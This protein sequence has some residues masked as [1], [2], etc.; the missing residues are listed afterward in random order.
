MAFH[1]IVRTLPKLAT[2]KSC[3]NPAGAILP[4]P[5]TQ[6]QAALAICGFAVWIIRKFIFVSKNLSS[7]G[8]PSIIR[9]FSYKLEQINNFFGHK[10]AP[11]LS[12]VMIF[13]GLSQNVTPANN[14]G[15]LYLLPDY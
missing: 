13:A 4:K 3:F 11:V 12:A 6:I 14:E 10:N 7:E 9:R 15:R 1:A 5:L 2:F 8:F